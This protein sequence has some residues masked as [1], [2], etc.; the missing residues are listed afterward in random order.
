MK[1]GMLNI[2]FKPEMMKEG[3]EHW[4]NLTHELKSHFPS[5]KG[6]YLMTD[7][8][9]GKCVGVGLWDS[10]KDADGLTQN[11][12]YRNFLEKVNPCCARPIVR[13]Q[14]EMSEKSFQE[15]K[16]MAVM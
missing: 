4:F 3:V 16:K 2:Q 5:F 12:V 7:A 9:S 15:M 14:L 10:Q 11:N 1:V 8:K 6:A 13:E